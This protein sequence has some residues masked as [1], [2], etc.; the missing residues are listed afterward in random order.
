[1]LFF[2]APQSVASQV[3]STCSVVSVT[4]LP[5]AEGEH[6][7]SKHMTFKV[8]SELGKEQH[9]KASIPPTR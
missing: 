1:M 2:L 3:A 6:D 8:T 5:L 4:N 9:R 7:A